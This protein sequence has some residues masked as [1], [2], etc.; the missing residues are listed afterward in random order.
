MSSTDC[1]K[2]CGKGNDLLA[3]FAD[4]LLPLLIAFGAAVFGASKVFTVLALIVVMPVVILLL[5][6]CFAIFFIPWR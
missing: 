5:T 1:N 2:D 6:L 3:T 4:V